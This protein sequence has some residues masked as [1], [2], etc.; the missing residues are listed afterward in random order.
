MCTK[1]YFKFQERDYQN[2]FHVDFPLLGV[3]PSQTPTWIFGEHVY[4]E[5]DVPAEVLDW[6]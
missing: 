5:R 2:C 4:R 3:A 1:Y 6:A